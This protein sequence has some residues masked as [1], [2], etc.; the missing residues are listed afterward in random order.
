MWVPIILK[1]EIMTLL[2]ILGMPT[3]FFLCLI[4]LL[5]AIKA[6][7][8]YAALHKGHSNSYWRGKRK[9]PRDG[10]YW[11]SQTGLERSKASHKYADLS[12][13]I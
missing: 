7:G 9:D 3:N 4:I 2:T 8:Y 6:F 12:G 5:L 11:E 1:K 13:R 10:G